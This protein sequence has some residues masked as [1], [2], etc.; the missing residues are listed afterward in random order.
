[1]R[2]F[3]L[4]KKDRRLF[5]LALP[6]LLGACASNQFTASAPAAN[7]ITLAKSRLYVYSF[8]DV[9]DSEFGPMMLA[10]IDRQL[11]AELAK[12]S[13]TARVL[14]FKDSEAGKYYST[15]NSG[16]SVPTG[17]TISGNLANEKS[18][19]TNYRLVIFPSDMKITGAWMHYQVRW[20]LFDAATNKRVW[21]A[22]SHGKHMNFAK[23]DEDPQARAKGIVDG[24]VGE[25]RKSRLL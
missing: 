19:A 8:M 10:E 16:M 24:F 14:R 13:V 21:V 22:T 5:L 1:M 4:S 7:G 15:T 17:Q 9:R 3:I 11:V 2:E 12:A 6:G 25:L 18:L 23:N 20:E